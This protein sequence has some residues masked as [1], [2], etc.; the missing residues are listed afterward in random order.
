MRVLVI[1]LLILL[2]TTSNAAWHEGKINYIG[3]GYNGSTITLILEGWSRSDCTCYSSWPSHMCLT[4][5]RDTSAF[6]Q[7]LILSAKARQ[8]P[9]KV[10]INENTCSIEAISEQN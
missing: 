4:N 3:I 8:S 5:N 6:E 7:S 10:Y 9:I 1:A 2:S